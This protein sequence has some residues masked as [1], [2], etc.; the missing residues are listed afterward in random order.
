[1]LLQMLLHAAIIILAAAY[2]DL[3]AAIV[4]FLQAA[5]VGVH[6]RA[7]LAEQLRLLVAARRLIHLLTT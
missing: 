3:I 4:K 1:M 6:A 7:E 5:A 2:R